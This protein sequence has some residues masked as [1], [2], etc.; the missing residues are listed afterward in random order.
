MGKKNVM[1]DCFERHFYILILSINY[2]L[3]YVQ[4]YILYETLLFIDFPIV[5]EIKKIYSQLILIMPIF[6][7]NIYTI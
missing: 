5:S 6:H 1:I 3:K 4:C 2:Y 7:K